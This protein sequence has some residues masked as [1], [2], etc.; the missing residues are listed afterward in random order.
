MANSINVFSHFYRLMTPDEK[1]E[2]MELLDIKSRHTFRRMIQDPQ[3]MTIRQGLIVVEYI[4]S[5]FEFQIDLP[6]L[7]KKLHDLIKGLDAEGRDKIGR[8][9][10]SSSK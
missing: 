5:R 8:R 10:L 6:A 2:L 3:S 1:S 4:Q 7:S 9:L